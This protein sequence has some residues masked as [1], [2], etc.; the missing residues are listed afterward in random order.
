MLQEMIKIPDILHSLLFTF[1][2]FFFFFFFFFY[3]G[4]FMRLCFCLFDLFSA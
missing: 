3:R 2:F 1:C 4:L